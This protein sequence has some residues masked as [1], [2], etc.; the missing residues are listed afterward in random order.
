L[1]MKVMWS[2]MPCPLPRGDG[3]HAR[4]GDDRDRRANG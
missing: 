4:S 1:A 2:A 3:S